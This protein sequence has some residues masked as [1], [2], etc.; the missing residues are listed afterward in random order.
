MSNYQNAPKL[1]FL[2]MILF[3]ISCSY[4]KTEKVV[5]DVS[6]EVS[7]IGITQNRNMTE[8]DKGGHFYCNRWYRTANNDGK[9]GEKKVCDFISQHLIQK[10]RG[11]IRISCNGIDMSNTFH[12]F[13]E[14][15]EENDWKVIA[16]NIFNHM[17]TEGTYGQVTDSEFVSVECNE[18]KSKKGEWKI[19]FISKDGARNYIM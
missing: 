16:R 6:G 4:T 7:I 17:E 12:I 15:N 2:L 18:D 10:K 8:Y 13:V 14:P 3:G 9:L 1:T 11:Y 19:V 5:Q